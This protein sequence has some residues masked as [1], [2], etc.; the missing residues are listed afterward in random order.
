MNL[1][2]EIVFHLASTF[3]YYQNDQIKKSIAKILERASN[4]RL[5]YNNNNN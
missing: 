5:E 4:N 2:D 3:I 1:N